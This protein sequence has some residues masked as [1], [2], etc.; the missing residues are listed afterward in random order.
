MGAVD[1]WYRFEWQHRGSPHVH[2][3]A[4]LAD[5]PDVQHLLAAEDYSEEVWRMS[6]ATLTALSAPSTLHCKN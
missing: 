1:F 2:G 6:Q 4:W 5:V 3:I